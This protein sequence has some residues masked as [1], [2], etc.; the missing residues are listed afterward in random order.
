MKP[1]DDEIRELSSRL[2]RDL[3]ALRGLSPNAPR[4][5]FRWQLLIPAACIAGAAL[6][7][8]LA[9]A[10]R[11]GVLLRAALLVATPLLRNGAE[12]LS[13]AQPTAV[14]RSR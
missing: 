1:T 12:R 8:C 6:M 13:R 10:A 14:A 3:M 9:P 5:C 11:K 7:F 4:A 2:Q